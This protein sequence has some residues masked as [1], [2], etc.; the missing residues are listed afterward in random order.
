M[1]AVQ[2]LGGA[3]RSDEATIDLGPLDQR[4]YVYAADGSADHHPAGGDRPAA[5]AAGGDPPAHRRRGARGGGRRLLR[6]RRREPAGHGAG[7]HPQRRRGRDRAGRIHDHPAGGEG[8]AGRQR[9]DRR[10]EGAGGGAGAP[11]RGDDDEVGDPRALPEHRVPGQ[12]R[13][14]RAGGRRD[15]LRRRGGPAQHRPVGVPRRAHRQPEPLRPDPR[16]GGVTRPARRRAPAHGRR[17]VPHRRG[18]RLRGAAPTSPP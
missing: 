17:G 1:P 16:T 2:V 9:P 18:G 4:S 12:R 10:P 8:G 11:A 14:R 5:G 15:V 6:P 3:G 13:L 7:P